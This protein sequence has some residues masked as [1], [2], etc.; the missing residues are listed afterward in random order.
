MILSF[1]FSFFLVVVWRI[2]AGSR[3][4]VAHAR[5][6]N[7]KKTKKNWWRIAEKNEENGTERNGCNK[8][9]AGE[10]KGVMEEG[11]ERDEDS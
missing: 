7:K 6:P 4:E 10:E 11:L 8:I 1:F 2:Q 9:F 3:N 5:E